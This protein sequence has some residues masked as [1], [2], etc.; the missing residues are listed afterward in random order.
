MAKVGATIKVMPDGPERDLEAL[1]KSL[2]SRTPGSV[3]L[4]GF[5]EEP[6]AFGLKALLA[7]VTLDDAEGGTQPVEDAWSGVEGVQ[8][9]EVV[10][11]SRLLE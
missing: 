1:R 4:A 11:V 7:S 9:V 3:T 10:E 5:R 8:S 6:I 2:A